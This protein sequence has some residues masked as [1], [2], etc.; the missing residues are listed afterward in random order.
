[1]ERPAQSDSDQ[2]SADPETDRVANRGLP[3][4]LVGGIIGGTALA[5]TVADQATKAL[6]VTWLGADQTVQRWELAGAWLAFE[7]VENT[8]AAFGILAGQVWLLSL[9]AAAVAFGFLVAFRK[10][11]PRSHWLRL[12]VSLIMGGGVGNLVDRLRLG[13]VVDFL[14]VGAWPKFNLA[15]SAITIGLMLLALTA[16][17][18][19]SPRETLS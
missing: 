15:D 7:Y 8:G 2:I 11:L 3:W 19:E 6:I 18:E 9:L 4:P 14:A 5:V 10:E 17:R 16:L 1:M 12:S 13:Y